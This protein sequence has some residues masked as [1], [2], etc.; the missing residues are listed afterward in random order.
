MPQLQSS[1]L[2]LTV[3][4][5]PCTICMSQNPVQSNEHLLRPRHQ[6]RSLKWE[7]GHSM[8]R[9][10]SYWSQEQKSSISYTTAEDFWA[11]KEQQVVSKV[12]HLAKPPT[13]TDC[14]RAISYKHGL[15]GNHEHMLFEQSAFG[16]IV[17]VVV[18]IR[19][20]LLTVQP[21]WSKTLIL[22]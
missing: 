16:G 4:L 10:N 19:C 7:N 14:S 8:N 6:M 5:R 1:R 18:F 21:Y 2:P 17:M 11:F 9:H 22:P 20:N 15:Y 13:W 3:S 12:S